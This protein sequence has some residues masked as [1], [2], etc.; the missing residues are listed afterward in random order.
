MVKIVNQQK[1]K[2]LNLQQVR[3]SS[4]TADI[5]PYSCK[6]I[7]NYKRQKEDYE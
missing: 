2:K 4:E 5:Y 3:E 1:R 6:V 7:N